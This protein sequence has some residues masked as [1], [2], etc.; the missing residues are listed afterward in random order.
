[1]GRNGG[2]EITMEMGPI[3]QCVGLTKTYGGKIALNQI[4][5]NLERSAEADSWRNFYRRG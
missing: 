2:L 4:Y 3:V 1:M 5:L